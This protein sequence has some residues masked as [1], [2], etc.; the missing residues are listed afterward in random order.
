MNHIGLRVKEKIA[1]IANYSC[2]FILSSDG[3]FAYHSGTIFDVLIEDHL[4]KLPIK[5][6]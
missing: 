2:F 5:V 4:R 3:H 1:F 6:E